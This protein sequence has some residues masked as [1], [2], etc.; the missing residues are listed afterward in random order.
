MQ[1]RG[2]L[3]DGTVFDQAKKFKFT[4]DAG[5]VI[6]V[7]TCNSATNCVNPLNGITAFSNCIL[8]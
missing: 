5:E 7:T 4:I 8:F 2:T 3:E 6:K 1:Y